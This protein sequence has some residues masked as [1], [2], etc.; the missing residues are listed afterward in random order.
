ML[1]GKGAAELLERR[2]IPFTAEKTVE[3]ILNH[4]QTGSCPMEKAVS[5][6]ED[7]K[8]MIEAIRKAKTK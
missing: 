2:G 1:A 5:G 8:T 6:L 3:V 7:P 4:E